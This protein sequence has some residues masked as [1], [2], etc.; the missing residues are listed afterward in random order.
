MTKW[1]NG[2]QSK[3]QKSYEKLDTPVHF[4]GD[5]PTVQGATCSHFPAEAQLKAMSPLFQTSSCF[6]LST[7]SSR[8]LSHVE[9]HWHLQMAWIH[10]QISDQKRRG[11]HPLR[12]PKTGSPFSSEPLAVQF[13][14]AIC[15]LL[16]LLK[17]FTALLPTWGYLFLPI[18]SPCNG[19]C[20]GSNG[21]CVSTQRDTVDDGPLQVAVVIRNIWVSFHTAQEGVN[22]SRDRPQSSNAIAC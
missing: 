8:R 10:H 6:Q 19:S 13:I 7:H 2:G 18:I 5:A 11:D 9:A 14:Q 16:C 22:C 12:L 17:S 21:V 15:Q 3:K 20:H 4:R 1:H